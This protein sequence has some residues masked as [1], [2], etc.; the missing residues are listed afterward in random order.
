MNKFFKIFARSILSLLL[1]AV[2]LVAA[3]VIYM[4]VNYYRIEDF[5]TLETF[6][7]QPEVIK[8]SEEY[9]AL[10]YNIGFGAYNH[11][12]SFFM[13]KGM[14]NDGIKVAGKGS[15]AKSKEVVV[16]NTN[17][18][19]DIANSKDA[20]FYLFQEVDTK[21]TRSYNVINMKC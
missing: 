4:S 20:N 18:V 3:Y 6:N 16:E 19:M 2:V 5:Q 21:S 7:Q 17:G 13:D 14:M 10:T 8:L 9:T 11:E 12:F 15:V 1:I